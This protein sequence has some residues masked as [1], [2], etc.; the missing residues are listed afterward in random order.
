MAYLKISLQIFTK[1][2]ALGALL[3][4]LLRFI[5]KRVFGGGYRMFIYHS[6]HPY[7]YI[8]LVAL[9]LGVAATVWFRFFTKLEGIKKFIS[10]IATL[11]MI[12]LLVSISGGILWTIHYMY[13]GYFPEGL[14][15]WKSILLGAIDGF[16]LGGLI[17]LVSVP[18]NIFSFVIGFKL[19]SS[20]EQYDEV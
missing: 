8:Y 11:V 5:G 18:F 4:H 2:F 12:I 10:V 7:Q 17:I 1:S 9:I 14:L 16:V 15:F 13:E 20:L 19:L 6:S 3:Y